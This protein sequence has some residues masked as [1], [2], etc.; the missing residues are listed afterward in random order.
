MMPTPMVPPPT[1]RA[2]LRRGVFALRHFSSSQTRRTAPAA[3][4]Y[5]RSLIARGGNYM[6]ATYKDIGVSSEGHVGDRRDPAAAAQLLRQFA[7]QP[8]RRCLRGVR[9]RRQH[10]R[11]CAVRP[12]QVV[13]R[14]RRLRQPAADRR[15]RERQAPLQGGD[16]PVP[17]QEAQRSAAIQGAG[18]R[19]RPRPRRDDRLPRHLRR[20]ALRRQLHAARLPSRLLAHLHPAAPDRPA[21]GEP[22]VLYRPPHRRRGGRRHGAWPTCWCRSPTCARRR[23]SSPT[24]SPSPRRSPSCRRARPCAAASPTAPRSPPS[25]S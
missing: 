15:G 20:G 12:G 6:S 1:T 23:W 25:A 18:D 13:L 16:P 4:Q 17:R 9:P 14:R 21:E 7:D 19:R 2:C 8:D 5:R 24:R 22:D 11:L 3:G 10:P